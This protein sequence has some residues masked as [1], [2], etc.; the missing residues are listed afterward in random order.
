MNMH[1]IKKIRKK[2]RKST[3]F[4]YRVGKLLIR[5]VWSTASVLEKNNNNNVHTVFLQKPQLTIAC[6]TITCIV[7]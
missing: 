7:C 5:F 1:K 3:G 2:N 4:Q 6:C